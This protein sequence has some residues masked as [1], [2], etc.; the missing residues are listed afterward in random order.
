MS[1]RLP[2]LLCAMLSLAAL[3]SCEYSIDTGPHGS[4]SIHD[5]AVRI[6]VSGAPPALVQSDG[7][8]LIGGR[9][10][11]QNAGERALAQRYY[12][13]VLSVTATGRATGKA[14]AKL[15][16]AIVGSLFSALWHDNSSIIKRTADTG[17]ADIKAKVAALCAQL[18]ALQAAQNALAA[19]QPA[20]MPYRVVRHRDVTACLKGAAGH[21]TVTHTG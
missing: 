11:T 13:D 7:N 14:G 19:K 5:N 1:R 9:A 10:V 3:A 17:K 21:V 20:F 8:L 18:Q 16:G 4:L 6:S 2:I 12:Q 15:G